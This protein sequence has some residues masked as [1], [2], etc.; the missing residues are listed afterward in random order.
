[1]LLFVTDNA[2]M[3]EDTGAYEGKSTVEIKVCLRK[4]QHQNKVGM[5]EFKALK[6]RGILQL[7]II[8]RFNRK[9]ERIFK[10]KYVR[11]ACLYANQAICAKILI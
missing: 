5:V 2:L 11:H 6:K 8:S 3:I 10:E 7:R 1:M 9:G 4:V